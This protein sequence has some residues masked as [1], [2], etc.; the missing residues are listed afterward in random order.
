MAKNKWKVISE[1]LY[2]QNPDKD[3]IF[4]HPKQCR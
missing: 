2:L 3:K 4:R 1:E